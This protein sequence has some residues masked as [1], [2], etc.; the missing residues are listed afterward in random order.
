MQSSSV[1][2][3]VAARFDPAALH[4]L[5][6]PRAPRAPR[7]RA[8]AQPPDP[9]LASPAP[10]PMAEVRRAG[11]TVFH[12]DVLDLARVAKSHPGGSFLGRLAG[13]DA[14][15]V[16]ENAHGT[17]SPVRKMLARCKVGRFAVAT[18]D[19]LDRDLL[20]LRED[21]VRE[22]LF[23]YPRLRLVFDVLRWTTFFGLA[24][25]LHRFSHAASFAF[26]LLGTV[27]VVWWIH[28]AGHDAIFDDE[29]RTRR[30][31]DALGVLVLGMPQQ[32]YHYGVHRLHHGFTNIIGVDRALET[33][34]LSW[35]EETAREKA[36]LFRRGRVFQWFLGVIPIA[37]P[38]LLVSAVTYSV[39][40]RQVALLVALAVRWAMVVTFAFH[41]DTPFLIFAPWV[42]GSILAF[43]AGLNHFH[44]PMS[45][46]TPP[47]HARAIFERTQNIDHAGLFWHWLSG[48][49]DL[50][51]EHH[52]FP[53]I[54]SYRYRAI[55]PRVRALA[56]RHGAPYRV[57]TRS[58]AVANLVRSLLSALPSE[59]A[60]VV[61]APAASRA[62]ASKLEASAAVLV[63]GSAIL[64]PA[65]VATGVSV[66][67]VWSF[68][69]AFV[70]FGLL[71][72]VEIV[73]GASGIGARSRPDG[74]D[75]S[76]L[77]VAPRAQLWLY[78]A[79]HLL[80]FPYVLWLVARG[81]LSL[82]ETIGAG[83]SLACMG[84]TVGGLGGHELMHKRSPLER[85]LG[86]G[87]YAT[88]N[89]GHFITSHIGGH[90]VNVGRR[91]D[92]GTAR[93]GETI[94]GFLYRAVVHGLVGAFRLEAE[95]QEKKGRS[96]WSIGNFV[97]RYALFTIALW[98]G[99][100]VLGGGAM[101]RF[102]LIVSV[103]T[104]AFMELFNYI[105]HYGLERPGG[106]AVRRA[107]T[108]PE[109]T[110]ESNNKV[111]NWFIF[112][113]G[114]HG[115][116]HRKPAHGFERLTLFHDKD[117][118]PHGI[119]LMALLSFVSPLYLRTMD[120]ILERRAASQLGSAAEARRAR[121]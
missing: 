82:S 92:W 32:G 53:G 9:G 18:R 11:H 26:V 69:G 30:I 38:A 28:D 71:S 44:L 85:L 72:V 23:A 105:S 48:G 49:L 108:E 64:M 90:H 86:I 14:T 112:N 40:K 33:G 52:L 10:I 78:A 55:A 60:A 57:T 116:H 87:L 45:T 4:F 34:P 19:P 89:Y 76:V 36:A 119:A 27:D 24:L 29:R 39:K 80:V 56:K 31:I 70:V 103:I 5:H 115:H 59:H 117:Y 66:G 68:A 17:T 8:A 42:A 13:Q 67:G 121:A 54:P 98:T 16:L 102:F 100:Y 6:A 62:K 91:E 97:V 51:I 61:P 118:I 46:T 20:A 37:G 35:S 50:H 2:L 95:R 25:L 111:V 81:G 65:L 104:V 63:R 101:L 93:R 21:F 73:L 43:M 88:A 15:L 1:N 94:Y 84:G 47:S 75:P 99:L 113:A 12:G 7:V 77:G 110:W 96:R 41:F 120:R 3:P 83:A 22:G 114:M 74:A 106:A 109:H 79:G 58:G 107:A